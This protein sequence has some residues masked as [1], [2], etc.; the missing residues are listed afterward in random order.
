MT[1]IKEVAQ[2]GLLAMELYTF[3]TAHRS[4]VVQG[5]TI[6]ELG[7]GQTVEVLQLALRNGA[8][9]CSAI[10]VLEYFSEE[11]IAKLQIDYEIYDGRYL[12]Y[13]NS[14]FDRV[15]ASTVFQHLRY[16]QTT[17]RE[18]RRVLVPEGILACRVD[19][20]D[21]YHLKDE[22]RWV[23]CLKHSRR[24]WNAMKWNRASYVNR[25][26]Y[27]EWMQLIKD[28]GFGEIRIVKRTSTI[29]KE[30]HPKVPY[31]HRYSE[32]DVEIF[33]FDGLFKKL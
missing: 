21:P 22:R 6:L 25:L 10:D 4:A 28:E 31:L 19:L 20:R 17:L 23:E 33:G 30:Q 5:K 7:P 24:A 1:L 16:P 2:N 8:K 14:C 18:I 11:T 27:S 26:R 12:P 32:A 15:W 3:Y 13:E 9:R 29:L